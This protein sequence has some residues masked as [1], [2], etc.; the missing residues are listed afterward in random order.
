VTS[1]LELRSL[2]LLDGLSNQLMAAANIQAA[3]DATLAAAV[4]LCAAERGALFVPGKAGLVIVA[5]TGFSAVDVSALEPELNSQDSTVS[6]CARALQPICVEDFVANC[7]H[8]EAAIAM[9][10]GYRAVHSV[11]I[12]DARGV[13]LCVITLFFSSSKALPEAQSRWIR[14]F[15]RQLS[16]FSQRSNEKQ[17]LGSTEE[18]FRSLFQESNDFIVMADLKQTITYCNPAT[19]LALGWPTEYMIGRSIADFIP[20]RHFDR[21]SAMLDQKLQEGGSTRYEVDVIARDGRRMTWEINSRLTFG[22]GG[23]PTGLHAIGRDVTSMRKAHE[24]LR[25]SERRLRDADQRKD[26][27]LAMLAHELRNPLAPIRTAAYIL[28]QTPVTVEHLKQAGEILERQV[29]HVSKIV[30]DL[31]DV[32]RVTRG[33]V[34]FDMKPTD[35]HQVVKVAVE[36]AQPLVE[37]K[38]HRLRVD[39]PNE[40]LVLAGESVRLIQLVANLLINAARHSGGNL[41]IELTVIATPQLVE[42]HVRD[43][44][45]GI[46]PEFLP[47]I[48]ELFAQSER[49]IARSEGGLGIGLAL[50]RRIAELHGG[51]VEAHS[52]GL[53]Q[54]AHFVVFLPRLN[55]EPPS[56]EGSKQ[57][58]GE[59][60]PQGLRILIVDDNE[61]AANS[62]A[63]LL[64]LEGHTTLVAHDA[65]T[66]L[67][68]AR[69]ELPDIMLL[70]IGLPGMSGHELA[71]QLRST[72]T[73]ASATLV[74]VTGYGQLSDRR[75]S[76]DAGFDYHLTKPAT[77]DELRSIFRKRNASVAVRSEASH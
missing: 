25:Q 31:L 76:A 48:F 72:P 4:R 45:A 71:M 68:R 56:V 37:A 66:A 65:L 42:I 67:E 3:T 7:D 49:S 33:L 43:H 62:L 53:G 29:G 2:D 27:F 36:Q 20:P 6:A 47:H 64:Q 73:T 60:A 13:L 39:M 30:D 26:E 55:E 70:D 58:A 1:D 12:L 38:G 11:P 46:A 21:T 5:Q 63:M 74:A 32:S 77:I 40:P 19:S 61:D 41:D 10:Y 23:K 57:D 8:A 69:V 16:M 17:S 44:G 51:S 54:G 28:K 14:V 50:V 34:A 18:R 75:K 24:E 35:L 15:G 22:P 9:R 59:A 52:D